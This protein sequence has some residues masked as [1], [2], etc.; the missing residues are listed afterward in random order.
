MIHKFYRLLLTIA[1]ALVGWSITGWFIEAQPLLAQEAG[2][3]LVIPEQRPKTVFSKYPE[4]SS[5]IQKLKVE[6]QALQNR[7]SVLDARTKGTIESS[8][9]AVTTMQEGNKSIRDLVTH[10]SIL[11]ALIVFI[12]LGVI[13][14]WINKRIRQLINE[15]YGKFEDYIVRG[16]YALIFQRQVAFDE[17]ESQFNLGKNNYLGGNHDT[18]I[19]QITEGLDKSDRLAWVFN[20]NKKRL[21]G[22]AGWEKKMLGDPKF[23]ARYLA[24]WKDRYIPKLEAFHYVAEADGG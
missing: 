24:L 3:P 4:Q 5:D 10:L 21:G 18:A 12:P 22:L 1:I 16:V 19:E 13:R 9:M 8:Q 14:S 15:R 11:L 2:Q 6:I 23:K 20:P 7:I 17:A